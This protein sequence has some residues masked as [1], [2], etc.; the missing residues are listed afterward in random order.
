MTL[1]ANNQNQGEKSEIK[2]ANICFCDYDYV[3]SKPLSTTDY[4]FIVDV[5]GNAYKVQVKSSNRKCEGGS[6]NVM[7]CKG[8]NG[9]GTKGK[10]PYPETS[11]D[12]F[13]VH[14]IEPDQ[15]FMIPR[16]ATGDAQQIRLSYK[17]NTK[18]IQYLNNWEFKK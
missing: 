10:Y 18:Y 15:W 17:E 12:F 14:D 4:E 11:I 3:V 5:N 9:C 16:S 6:R 2:F 8:T 13:A 7:I 1:S